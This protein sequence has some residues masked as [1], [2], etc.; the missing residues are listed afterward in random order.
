MDY[1]KIINNTIQYNTYCDQT[2]SWYSSVCQGK[3]QNSVKVVVFRDVTLH[4]LV[5]GNNML[6]K[7]AASIFKVTDVPLRWRQQVL[8][9]Y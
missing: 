3:Y 9:K 5:M 7:S 6:V 2:F 8:L 1:L 4:R